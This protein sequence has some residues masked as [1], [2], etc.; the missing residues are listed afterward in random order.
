MKQSIPFE[1]Y[2]MKAAALDRVVEEVLSKYINLRTM[3]IH[4][5]TLQHLT[6]VT[7]N[8]KYQRQLLGEGTQ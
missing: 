5:Q 7:A 4:K 1:N 3:K 6:L 2:I 8:R